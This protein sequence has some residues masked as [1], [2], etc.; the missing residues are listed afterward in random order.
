MKIEKMK[1]ILKKDI[2]KERYKHTIR[3]TETAIKLAKNYKVDTEKAHI[4]ALLHDSAKYKDKDTLLKKSQEFGIILDAVMKN[5]PHLIHP[6]LGAELAKVKYN[7]LDEDILNAIK[8][9]TTGRKNMSM[10]EKIIFIADYIEPGRNFPGLEK[11][12]EISFEDIDLGIILAMDNT[13]KY[14]I[15]K[16][17]LIHPNT[18]ETRNS[19][20]LKRN[21]II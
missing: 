14:I 18:I 5:N 16:G 17:W 10:L 15:N 20:I 4:A 13:L 19:L 21:K 12:R 2:D 9:H 1:S 7:I 8:Y 3:V 6:F 11:I